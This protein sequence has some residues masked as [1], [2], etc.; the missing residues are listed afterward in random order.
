MAVIIDRSLFRVTCAYVLSL[1]VAIEQHA[2]TKRSWVACGYF[3]RLQ[4]EAMA[5][6]P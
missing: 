5:Q 2:R 6:E 3:D 4:T 1:P